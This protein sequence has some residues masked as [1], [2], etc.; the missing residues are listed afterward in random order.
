MAK[1][2]AAGIRKLSGLRKLR[3]HV[4]GDCATPEAASVVGQAMVEHEKKHGRAAWSYTHAWREVPV[5][6]WKGARVLASCNNV[7]EVKEARAKGYGTAM[8]VPPHPTN[9]I[10]THEGERIVPCPAQ[11]KHDGKRVVTCEHCTLCN[12]PDFLRQQQLSVGFQP[13]S[14]TQKRV[15]R[16]LE[17]K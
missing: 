8:I 1:L 15:L 9:R 4:L 17:V 12:R 16:L 3:V 2:E 5:Q 13:D 6:A 7:G 14:G 11:F 10:Y